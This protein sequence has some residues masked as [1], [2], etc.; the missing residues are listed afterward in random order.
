MR[1]LLL[2]IA[3]APYLLI[4]AVDAWMHEAGRR[5]PRM[6]QALHAALALAMAVFLPAVFLGMTSIA[7]LALLA[8][9]VL[10]AWDELGYHAMIARSERRIHIASWIALAA[11]IVTWVVVG[12]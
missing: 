10:L 8:F 9:G 1:T 5:V 2:G 12:A 11:F 6:E 3:I 4:A 7:V